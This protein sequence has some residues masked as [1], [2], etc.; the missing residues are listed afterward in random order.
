MKQLLG[1]LVL[2][3]L[4]SS[5]AYAKDFSE[6]IYVGMT[7]KEVKKRTEIGWK[8]SWPLYRT[9][10]LKTLGGINKSV[11]AFC[12]Y[13]NYSNQYKYFPEYNVEIFTHTPNQNSGS[14]TLSNWPWYVFENVTKPI[15]CKTSGIN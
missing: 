15:R 2:G 3:L 1:I 4:L 7:K 12:N 8:A 6:L 11:S 10:E 5:N 14:T 9:P 13:K